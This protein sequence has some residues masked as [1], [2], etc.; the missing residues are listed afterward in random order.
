MNKGGKG[1]EY[2]RK[3]EKEMKVRKGDRGGEKQV[4]NKLRDMGSP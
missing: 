2:V 1:I 4:R 3:D